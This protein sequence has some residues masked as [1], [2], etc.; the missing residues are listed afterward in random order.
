MRD[1]DPSWSN[2]RTGSR[3]AVISRGITGI[4]RAGRMQRAASIGSGV[5]DLSR[6]EGRL[7]KLCA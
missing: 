7:L 3:S 1:R 6:L 4:L 5:N 2:Q